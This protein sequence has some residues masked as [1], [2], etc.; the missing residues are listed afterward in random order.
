MTGV[1]DDSAR[2]DCSGCAL[3]AA[4][5]SP[6]AMVRREF[7]RAAGM[8]L[9]SIGLLGGG[10]SE[11]HAMPVTLLTG[12]PGERPEERRYPV[13]TVDGVSVD[14]DNSVIIARAGGRV[15]AFSLACPHQNTALR[16]SVA[17]HQFECPKH[18]SRYRDDGSFIEGR[19][20]RAMD[21]L[22]IRRDAAMLVVDV[23]KMFQQDDQPKEWG[24]A[25]IPVTTA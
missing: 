10:A 4:A 15:Y 25:S 13:P 14:K 9:A 6:A 18:K 19:A 22:S 16:W 11:L 8:A 21:R 7:L 2:S 20:T 1:N 12:L 17:D 24:A 3:H 23:D 5:G